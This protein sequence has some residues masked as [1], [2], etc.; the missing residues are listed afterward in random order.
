MTAIVQC[1]LIPHTDM[2]NTLRTP[3]VRTVLNR[4][5][6]VAA[7][8]QEAPR[9]RKPGLLLHGNRYRARAGRRLRVH[10]HV[11]LAGGR[12]RSTFSFEQSVRTP[13]LSSVRRM[14]FPPSIRPRQ[15]PTTVRAAC[16]VP[17]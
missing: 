9:W 6:A 14:E 12:H 2:A 16:S 11:H 4:L 8:D 3:Q 7:H 5:F 10:L 17:S 15:S 13:L 1:S